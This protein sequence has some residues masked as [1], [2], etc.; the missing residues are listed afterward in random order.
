M[1]ALRIGT[2]AEKSPS[3]RGLHLLIRAT[4]SKSRKVNANAATPRR[5]IYDGRKGS[6]RYFTVTGDCIGAESQI[7]E[8]PE[9]QAM[10]DVFVAKWFPER[11]EFVESGDVKSIESALDDEHVANS[12]LARKMDQSGVAYLEVTIQ[13]TR[14]KVKRTWHFAES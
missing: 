2:Y 3:G 1:D 14:P 6:A 8:G 7:R 13:T 4:I 5:E 10:L 12:Y 11:A 9:A